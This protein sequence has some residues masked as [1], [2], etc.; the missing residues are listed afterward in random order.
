VVASL[1]GARIL[2]LD[3]SGWRETAWDELEVVEHHRRFLE[4][5]M[6]YLR[7]VLE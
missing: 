1:P 2:Q 6:R 3:D 4:E 7:H 5:P